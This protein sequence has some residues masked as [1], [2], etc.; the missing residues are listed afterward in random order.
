MNKKYCRKEKVI[1]R[2]VIEL[3]VHFFNSETFLNILLLYFSKSFFVVIVFKSCFD[4]R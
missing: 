1:G 2:I 4:I 3:I